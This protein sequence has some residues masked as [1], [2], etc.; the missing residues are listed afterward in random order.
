[1]E[2][3]CDDCGE[4]VEYCTCLDEFNDDDYYDP[5]SEMFDD[6]DDEEEGYY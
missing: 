3:Y 6:D 2:D 1:V 5:D 4:E